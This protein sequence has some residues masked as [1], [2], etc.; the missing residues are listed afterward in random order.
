[1]YDMKQRDWALND[2]VKGVS[3]HFQNKALMGESV[4]MSTSSRDCVLVLERE[5]IA[6]TVSIIKGN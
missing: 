1:M 4:Y 3:K 6:Y 2:A 5:V